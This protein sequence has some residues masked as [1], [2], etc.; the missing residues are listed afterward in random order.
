LA[1]PKQ[2]VNAKAKPSRKSCCKITTYAR[3][4]LRRLRFH[5]PDR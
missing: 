3:E 1:D 4:N 5:L 2:K